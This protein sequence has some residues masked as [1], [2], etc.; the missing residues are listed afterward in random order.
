VVV[1][2]VVSAATPADHVIISEVWYNIT[3]GAI[4]NAHEWIELYNPT[5]WTISLSGWTMEEMQGWPKTYKFPVWFVIGAWKYVL[6]A[7]SL[8]HFQTSY[9]GITPQIVMNATGSCTPS[10]TNIWWW[11]MVCLQLNNNGSPISTGVD[12]LTLKNIWWTIIDYV[13]WWN[14]ANATTTKTICR[15]N[16]TDTDLSWDWLSNCSASPSTWTLTFTPYLTLIW[17]T[18][19]GIQLGSIY[20]DLNAL[21]TNSWWT[22]LSSTTWIVNTWAVWS[23]ILNYYHTDLSGNVATPVS[24]I[25]N[26]FNTAPVAVSQSLI[27]QED[28]YGT[29]DFLSWATDINTGN[30]LSLSWIVTQPSNGS[31][32]TWWL[33]IPTSNYCGID[34]F[35]FQLKDNI[36]SGSNIVT[37][38]I[39]ITC[40]NDAPEIIRNGIWDK[41][42][43]NNTISFHMINTEEHVFDYVLWGTPYIN[44]LQ[45]K[46]FHDTEQAPNALTIADVIQPQFGTVVWGGLNFIYT[47]NLYYCNQDPV[48]GRSTGSDIM[49]YIVKD[50]SGAVSNTWEMNFTIL[51]TQDN[52]IAVSDTYTTSEE[53]I[54]NGDISINDLTPDLFYDTRATIVDYVLDRWPSHGAFNLDHRTGLFDYT[55][56]A[57]FCSELTWSTCWSF[58]SMID[59]TNPSIYNLVW[60]YDASTATYYTQGWWDF[61]SS[62]P[63]IHI[64]DE[65]GMQAYIAWNS[66]LSANLSY[67]YNSS[68]NI[69]TITYIGAWNASDRS[70]GLWDW[71]YTLTQWFAWSCNVSLTHPTDTTSSVDTVTHFYGI[72]DWS[73]YYQYDLLDINHGIDLT[74]EA[75]IRSWIASNTLAWQFDYYYDSWNHVGVFDY[76]GTWNP[77]N[78]S[79]WIGNS[80]SYFDK[81]QL[82]GAY[83]GFVW[84]IWW[85]SGGDSFTY[86][87][88]DDRGLQSTSTTVYL[89]VSC[90]ND[91]PVISLI[92]LDL[93]D[94]PLGSSYVDD[95][96]TAF[97]VEDGDITSSIVVSWTIDTNT[98]G[99]YMITYDITD[100]QWNTWIQV[101]RIVNVY[102]LYSLNYLTSTGG[103]VSGTTT[104]NLN[105]NSTWSSVTAVATTGYIFSWWSDGITTAT[106]SDLATADKT[107]TAQFTIN[108]YS[109]NYLTST[110]GT[111][112]G[113][114][115]QN[116][117]Y[118]STWSSVTAVATTGYIFSWWS[119]GITTATRSDLATA[120]KTVTAQ[121]TINQYSLNYLTST[122][123]TVSGTTTQNLNY[124]STWS[125]VTAVA[126]TGYIFSWWSDGITT[127]TRSDLATAD[128]T[129]TA[130]F[131]DNSIPVITVIWATGITLVAGTS[132][133]ESWATW[134]DNGTSGTTIVSWTVN[135]SVPGVYTITYSYTDP[136]GN[137]S[138]IVTRTVVVSNPPIS[139][140]SLGWWGWYT[141]S[142]LPTPTNTTSTSPSSQTTW[143]II[144]PKPIDIFNPSITDWYCYTAR[145]GTN[146][147]DSLSITTDPEFKPSLA[148]L[149]AYELT[150]FN[151]VDTFWPYTNLTREQAAKLFSNFAINVL[152]RK[153]DL[154]LKISYSDTKNADPTLKPYITLAYQLWLMKWWEGIFR[155]FDTITK[156]EFNA[157]LVRMILKSYLDESWS[158]WY[159]SY[160]WVATDLWIIKQ[161]AGLQAVNRH[162]AALMLFRAYK[163]QKFS[164]QTIDYESFVLDKR[165]EFVQS[166]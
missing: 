24:R 58:T 108:Q 143:I 77:I 51:C 19:F 61:T 20:T 139:W 9:P 65:V 153:P 100:S 161:W 72:Y 17:T 110:G 119:D 116:L 25:V 33:Y 52:P 53:T 135:T 85:Y 129:V 41:A 95:G 45:D 106:R 4:D 63:R 82:D 46:Y 80:S 75:N 68:T 16:S 142:P 6:I 104:Q 81:K 123:G 128:K 7:N 147:I 91:M 163:Q 49:Y 15:K 162:N 93:I 64:N 126:N 35:R 57:N 149:Y 84:A 31:I 166:N 66:V 145:T 118:N 12:S 13:W 8:S 56:D 94:I 131:V 18:P 159:S 122:G 96:A 92:G 136:S 83:V 29:I 69:A 157:V 155:P 86:H 156:A 138:T 36:G 154:S 117:N 115:T 37:G 21:Y 98:V 55:P 130:Q 152:C 101:T 105:Y 89:W 160:N 27:I 3:W 50:S 59:T 114:T 30:V 103:T 164:L 47:P 144:T 140:P 32:T 137:M 70:I 2:S 14:Y 28:T 79:I 48:S 109:L 71:S 74:N 151:S 54:I 78:Y 146:I 127:A 40:V 88:V 34:S 124:N 125:S 87:V 1:I 97:D 73:T 121:F 107:V 26:V 60:F 120:D 62:S 22:W 132:Y 76:V 113:T 134:T 133:T 42:D 10:L 44:A 111:V 99:S 148:F 39:M 67:S 158:T 141:A 43:E 112:S 23:Y 38:E 11:V 165:G 5:S 150:K 102:A 90:L